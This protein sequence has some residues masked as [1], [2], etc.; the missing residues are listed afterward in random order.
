MTSLSRGIG[1]LLWYGDLRRLD[2]Y[3][4]WSARNPEPRTPGC[5]AWLQ[6]HL[7]EREVENATR[8]ECLALQLFEHRLESLAGLLATS[9]LMAEVIAGT[10]GLVT[11]WRAGVVSFPLA[12]GGLIYL[13]Y[14]WWRAH[15]DVARNASDLETAVAVM[16]HV[17]KAV[18]NL[19]AL[20]FF[21]LGVAVAVGFS[22]AWWAGVLAFPLSLMALWTIEW[23]GFGWL[24][25]AT[26]GRT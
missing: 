9:V 2:P 12:M 24:K 20:I 18:E 15:E 11:T 7:E 23:R 4:Q 17:R 5:E 1:H 3:C 14:D 19:F 13:W 21:G 6:W 10:I 22:T 8:A 16:G 26:R 25:K